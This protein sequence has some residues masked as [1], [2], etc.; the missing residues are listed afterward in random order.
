MVLIPHGDLV[1]V[2]APQAGQRVEGPQLEV[3]LGA[4]QRDQLG[5]GDVHWSGVAR[6]GDLALQRADRGQDLKDGGVGP[7]FQVLRHVEP[8]A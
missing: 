2:Q 4:Q 3:G 6:E 5:V 1:E 8:E 7:A